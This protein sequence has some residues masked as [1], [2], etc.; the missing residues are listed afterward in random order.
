MYN[1]N[2]NNWR[3]WDRDHLVEERSYYRA[4]G[5]LPEM[6]SAKQLRSIIKNIDT[7]ETILDVGCASGH[8]LRSIRLLNKK[9]KYIGY[10]ATTK[11]IESARNIFKNDLNAEFIN[12]DIYE[13]E[14]H[15]DFVFCCN[16]LL[17]L[18]S[19]FIPLDNLLKSFKKKLII[20]TLL[21]QK[22]HLSQHLI[23]DDFNENDQ[24]TNYTY[25]N[26]YSFN[27]IEN[28]IK[29]F[30]P[31]IKLE[32]L[33]DVFDEKNVLEEYHAWKEKQGPGTTNVVNGIQ[34][35]GNKVFR[36]GWIVCTRLD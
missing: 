32:F 21:D 26:T 27:L 5:K 6:E 30:D 4:Q 9:C 33:P 1:I 31:T 28:L 16:V 7:Q 34:I 3:G 13:L 8:Y 17:H 25:Q 11:Y 29:K 19:I 18:P 23:E 12:G 36:W 22:S 2:D 20:R 14:E 24:P 10:D 35:A 15:A